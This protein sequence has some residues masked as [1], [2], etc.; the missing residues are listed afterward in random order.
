MDDD[1]LLTRS[2]HDHTGTHTA[3]YGSAPPSS[4][5]GARIVYR[6]NGEAYSSNFNANDPLIEDDE[7]SEA[8]SNSEASI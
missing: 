3:T 5:G 2:E 4:G 1:S 7:N 8:S 6:K